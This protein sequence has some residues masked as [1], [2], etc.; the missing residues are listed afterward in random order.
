MIFNSKSM[1]FFKFQTFKKL[2]T[3]IDNI[4]IL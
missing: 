4:S 3:S 2:W 1:N